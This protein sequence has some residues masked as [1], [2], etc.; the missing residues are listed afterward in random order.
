MPQRWLTWLHI[1]LGSGLADHERALPSVPCAREL[2]T[3]SALG[4]WLG[5]M[6]SLHMFLKLSAYAATCD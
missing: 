1:L 6:S 3:H 2:V 5:S 4:L